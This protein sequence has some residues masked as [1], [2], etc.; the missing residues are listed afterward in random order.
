MK[1]DVENYKESAATAKG[2]GIPAMGLPTGKEGFT[3]V[4]L[5]QMRK[6]IARRLVESKRLRLTFTSRWRSTWTMSGLP[7]QRSMSLRR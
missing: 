3:E 7:V 6:T 2:S 4:P 1:K 5:S